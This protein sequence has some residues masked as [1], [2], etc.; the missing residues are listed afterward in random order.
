MPRLAMLAPALARLVIRAPALVFA[1]ALGAAPALVLELVLVLALGAA[2]PACGSPVK[3]PA[4]PTASDPAAGA[5][6]GAGAAPGA[7]VGADAADGASTGAT[8]PMTTSDPAEPERRG[9]VRIDAQPGGK[10]FQGVWLELGGG[11]RWVID[12]R[13]RDVWRPF[14]DRAVLVTGRCYEPQ[15]QAIWA[16]HF[17]VTRMRFADP[18][19]PTAPILEVGPEIRL[20]GA[21]AEVAYPAGSKLAGTKDLVFRAEGGGE[22][23]LF[24]AVP[25][26]GQPGRF[27]LGEHVAI[28]ARPVERNLAYTAGP[29][30][31]H[32]WILDVRDAAAGPREPGRS[33]G[34]C[35][36]PGRS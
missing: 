11:A 31:P 24:G 2:V 10:R 13:A 16:Q 28:D 22:H 36:A 23:R 3:P 6:P 4:P 34:P 27:A 12:Y 18:G 25:G 8:P 21:F 20:R 26:A 14:A 33:Y 29:G 1:L 5:D 17:E 7:G 15:G 35:P 32:L 30:G 19:Q 9:T